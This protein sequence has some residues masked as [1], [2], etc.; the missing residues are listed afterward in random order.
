MFKPQIRS[1]E[2][3][4]PLQKS[5]SIW[6]LGTFVFLLCLNAAYALIELIIEGVETN[7]NIL[8]ILGGAY[9]VPVY[10]YFVASLIVAAI[11]FGYLCASLLK[12]R[13]EPSDDRV[14]RV[15]EE[16]LVNNRLQLERQVRDEF[17]KLSIG[18]FQNFEVLKNVDMNLEEYRKTVGKIAEASE[19]HEKIAERQI[20]ELDTIT[21][22]IEN[23]EHQLM[24]KPCLTSDLDIQK[25]S[26]IGEKIA[27]KL[28]SAGIM[29]VEDL[30]VEDASLI[31]AKTRLSKAKIRKL[32]AAAQ[33]LMIPGIDEKS[34]KALQK[35]GV[36]SIDV[37]AKQNPIELFRRIAV[38]ES[39]REDRPTLED[40]ISY[41][42]SAR[43]DFNGA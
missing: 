23:V 36:A 31:A 38:L 40:V 33:L 14:V 32:K 12:L 15:V 5:A 1:G 24:P 34:V 10:M 2:Q 4:V 7:I 37:L 42:R 35:A 21:K 9:Y 43:F 16:S 25:V 27:E 29:R 26:G 20:I 11:F 6:T 41:I 39:R 13:S 8:S 22:R 28:K 19:R 3:K 30:I 17:A 18:Q